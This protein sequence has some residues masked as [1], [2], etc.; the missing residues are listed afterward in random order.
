MKRF[1]NSEQ[2]SD[3]E[4][5]RC[6]VVVSTTSPLKEIGAPWADS[7]SRLRTYKIN[8]KAAW[9]FDKQGKLSKTV[10]VMSKGLKSLLKGF[11]HCPKVG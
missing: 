6:L 5:P 3:S 2:P 7:R 9:H 1:R 11:P 4:H 10:K 8:L